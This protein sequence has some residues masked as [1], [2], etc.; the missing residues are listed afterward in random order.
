MVL[1]VD[2]FEKHEYVQISTRSTHPDM[3]KRFLTM[4]IY[5]MNIITPLLSQQRLC[6]S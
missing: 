5:T 1:V 4:S 2:W 6:L 3:K